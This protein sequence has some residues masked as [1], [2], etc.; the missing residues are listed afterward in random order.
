MTMMVING[1]VVGRD[2]ED[3]VAGDVR[4]MM[5]VKVEAAGIRVML[6]LSW[7]E[8]VREFRVKFQMVEDDD[9]CDGEDDGD[10]GDDDGD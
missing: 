2:G 3:D 5:K 4:T 10:D 7:V 9:R 8:I 1:D 6:L